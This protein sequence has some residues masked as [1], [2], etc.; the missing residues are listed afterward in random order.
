MGCSKCCCQGNWHLG[1]CKAS[2]SFQEQSPYDF[3]WQGCEKIWDW[4]FVRP[5][6]VS[7]SQLL[8]AKLL[9]LLFTTFLYTVHRY[10]LDRMWNKNKNKS[11]IKTFVFLSISFHNLQVISLLSLA[12]IHVNLWVPNFV[13]PYNIKIAVE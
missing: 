3:Y 8:K 7:N 1:Y 5:W 9:N 4:Q 11:E 2:G 10:S 12:L 6:H 13:H